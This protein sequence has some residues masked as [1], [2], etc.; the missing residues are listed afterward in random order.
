VYKLLLEQAEGPPEEG[1]GSGRFSPAGCLSHWSG[2]T[3]VRSTAPYPQHPWARILTS[4]THT[5]LPLSALLS[6]SCTQMSPPYP[7]NCSQSSGTQAH[8]VFSGTQAHTGREQDP[9][10]VLEPSV[11]KKVPAHS[12]ARRLP[13][14]TQQGACGRAGGG[15]AGV[16]GVHPHKRT[17]S[18]APTHF[19][20]L[21][22]P[23]GFPG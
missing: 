10:H 21:Q 9:L 1:G 15:S 19:N 18:S 11:Y 16:L 13:W 8:T 3:G 20:C 5:H 6:L 12:W 7:P 17:P 22:T 2:D 14:R 23:R 4:L